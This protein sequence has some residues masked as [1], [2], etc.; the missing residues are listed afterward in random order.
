MAHPPITEVKT[1]YAV[2]DL[3][4]EAK[5]EKA[6]RR[7]LAAVGE[8]WRLA[9]RGRPPL[10]RPHEYA[11]ALFCKAFWGWPLREAACIIR[12]PKSTLHW[13]SKR[14]SAAWVLALVY[15][16]ADCLRRQYAVKAGILDS[17]GVSLQPRGCKRAGVWR[18]YYK[19]HALAEYA[20]RAHK[21]WF[22]AALAT[23]GNVA[24]ITVAPRLMEK[25]PPSTLYGDKGYDAQSL[26]RLAYRLGWSVCMQQRRT[27]ARLTGVRGKVWRSYD[28]RKRKRFRG[29]IEAMFGGFANRYNSRVF[30][31]RVG[32]R[33]HACLLWAAAHNIRTMAKSLLSYLLDAL[34]LRPAGGT[35]RTKTVIKE[36]SQVC[37]LSLE[38]LQQNSNCRRRR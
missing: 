5:V 38:V 34:G 32:T 29:R 3:P 1:V 28:D 15:K 6:F 25:A 24:D 22:A 23:R 10:R 26:Y 37:V 2:F 33:R 27:A 20:P 30:E 16:T 14:L 9:K 18:P 36:A 31:K 7:V 13:A 8:P 35:H 17:T 12:I 19:L 4:L 11:K 21:V